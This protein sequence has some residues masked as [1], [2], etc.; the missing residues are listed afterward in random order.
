[1]GP[2][3][4][5]IEWLNA[6]PGRKRGVA[7]ILLGFGTSLRVFGLE[8]DAQ[9]IEGFN[10]IVQGVSTSSDIAG[11]LM[12]IWGILHPLIASHET[13]MTQ[14]VNV[15]EKSQ[16]HTPDERTEVKA[17]QATAIEAVKAAQVETVI[18][19]AAEEEA[20]P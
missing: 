12:G 15:L 7:A 8:P 5:G 2:I 14:A 4:K 10:T 6:Y 11:V 13:R 1:V 17:L 9:A 19:K 20:K 3:L 18:A 16:A